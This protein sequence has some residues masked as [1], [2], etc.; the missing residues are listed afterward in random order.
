VEETSDM[1]CV[2]FAFVNFSFW[3]LDA[4]LDEKRGM[5]NRVIDNKENF[6]FG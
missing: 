2:S 3:D 1:D 4:D 6:C 5:S